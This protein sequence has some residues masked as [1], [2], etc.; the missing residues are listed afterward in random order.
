MRVGESDVATPRHQ[1][2]YLGVGRG[3]ARMGHGYD[4]GTPRRWG[5]AA[6]KVLLAQ[7][8]MPRRS[9]ERLSIGFGVLGV[10][11]GCNAYGV[12]GRN[13]THL[14]VPLNA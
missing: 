7:W 11:L 3:R 6:W 2:G 12:F 4:K 9:L 8:D 13:G 1:N 14:G 10:R 5:G